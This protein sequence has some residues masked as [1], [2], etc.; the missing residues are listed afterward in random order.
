MSDIFIP[1]EREQAAPRKTW[2]ERKL[3]DYDVV[4]ISFLV[5]AGEMKTHIARCYSIN[6]RTVDNMLNGYTYP[7][8][9]REH[10]RLEAMWK[11]ATKGQSWRESLPLAY[12]VLRQWAEEITKQEEQD[13]ASQIRSP[14]I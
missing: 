2:P 4:V 11:K 6:T 12:Y 10:P 1:H 3:S 13:G 14:W 5:R 8:V 9:P 7:E